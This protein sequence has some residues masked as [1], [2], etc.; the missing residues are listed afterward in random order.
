MIS[1]TFL[2]IPCNPF[3]TET[4]GNPAPLF[5]ISILA[6]NTSPARPLWWVTMVEE[7]PKIGIGIDVFD[8]TGWSQISPRTWSYPGPYPIPSYANGGFDIL[9]VG[10]SWGLDWDPTGLFDSPSITPNGDNFYQY[11]SSEMDAAIAS[12][13]TSFNLADRLKYVGK[14]QSL[15]Y[16]DL[17]QIPI[18]Y[19]LACYP[20]DPQLENF[21]SLLWASVYYPLHE[22]SISD[23]TT[24]RYATPADFEDFHPHF[25][26]S[27]YDAQWLHQIYNGLVQRNSTLN[28]SFGPW[29]AESFST[30]DGITYNV[31]IKDE[32]KWADG[33]PITTDDIIFN[34]NLTVTPTYSSPD[35]SDYV[36]YWDNNSITKISDK[37]SDIT[38]K[39]KYVFNDGNLALNLIPEHIWGSI[40]IAEHKET[41]QNWTENYPEK[42]FG[43]GPYMLEKYNSTEGYIHLVPNPYFVDL[44]G[45]SPQFEDIYFEF[46]DNKESAL[47]ALSSGLID[48]VDA[49]FSPQL[50]ELDHPNIDYTLCED[51]GTQEMALNMEHPILGTGEFCPIAGAESAKHVRKAISHVV[52]RERFVDQIFY[53]LANP[54]VTACPQVAV[55]F[56]HSLVPYEYNI[57]KAMYH[58][59]QAG[60]EIT[61]TNTGSSFV[62]SISFCFIVVIFGLLGA[63][64]WILRKNTQLNFEK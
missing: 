61:Y 64:L 12:Y 25:Y 57:E 46:Y 32:A 16:E 17:P 43:A 20:H 6:P 47:T 13:T 27:V 62:L 45:F 53:G 52:P 40:P 21:N 39:Q 41:A 36:A 7:L 11:N 3:Y 26:E 24:F 59:R 34:F 38:F 28:N 44:Y 15:L 51:P 35:Y 30:T 33:M 9:C 58:L 5:S 54:G 31:V 14:I 48:M 55:G 49:Q 50:N 10:W 42:M 23:Q 63:G 22:I 2:I 4:K 18:C 29:L 8:H 1:L 19:P 60:Y 56:N 37:E